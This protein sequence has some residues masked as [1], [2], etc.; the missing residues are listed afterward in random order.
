MHKTFPTPR[1]PFIRPDVRAYTHFACITMLSILAAN[2]SISFNQIVYMYLFA[3][4]F[5][6][7]AKLQLQTQI[8]NRNSMYISEFGIFD[9]KTKCKLIGINS[10]HLAQFSKIELRFGK[11]S[12]HYWS[13]FDSSTP[14]HFERIWFCSWYSFNYQMPSDLVVNVGILVPVMCGE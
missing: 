11:F 8:A 3:Y 6:L 4:R 5:D 12:C 1:N 10:M 7:A 13:T 14:L 2:E 9:F